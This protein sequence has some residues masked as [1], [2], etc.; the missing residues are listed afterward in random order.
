MPLPLSGFV[1]PQ[2]LSHFKCL[3][4]FPVCASLLSLP[5]LRLARLQGFTHLTWSLSLVVSQQLE[6][7]TLGFSFLGFYA[8][9]GFLDFRPL[10]PL[11]LFDWLLTSSL[12]LFRA[13]P[14]MA[15]LPLSLRFPLL[16]FCAFLIYSPVWFCF[17]P[18]I[19]S[20]VPFCVSAFMKL[21]LGF[22]AIC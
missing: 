10:V 20:S 5:S 11:K 2:V 4:P 16:R 17:F 8:F 21:S 22:H 19:S 3:P 1:F 14:F 13:F 12:S 6:R 7:L 9:S 15:Y 18:R